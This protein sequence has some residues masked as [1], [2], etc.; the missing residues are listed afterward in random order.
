MHP[1]PSGRPPERPCSCFRSPPS[2]NTSSSLRPFWRSPA[3]SG[4]RARG[5]RAL[6]PASQAPP[7][8]S[9]MPPP[10][11]FRRWP[12]TS[13]AT[14]SWIRTAFPPGLPAPASASLRPPPGTLLPSPFLPSCSSRKKSSSPP[15]LCMQLPNPSAYM[16]S[17]FLPAVMAALAFFTSSLVYGTF[18]FAPAS[19][20]TLF[21]YLSTAAS[22]SPY[23]IAFSIRNLSPSLGSVSG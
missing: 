22:S 9:A 16:S 7:P 13:R 17:Y 12:C 10:A 3:P 19:C 14:R 23:S 20:S 15:P 18:T 6:F 11:W 1:L 21:R 8:L 2:R 4:Y 5:R